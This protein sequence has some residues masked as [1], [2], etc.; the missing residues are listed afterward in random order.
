[1]RV[2]LNA[3]EMGYDPARSCIDRKPRFAAIFEM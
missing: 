1:M 3:P 2:A